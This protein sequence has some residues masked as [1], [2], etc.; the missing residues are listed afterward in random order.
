MN[1]TCTTMQTA[2]VT[3]VLSLGPLSHVACPRQ[4]PQVW[5]GVGGLIGHVVWQ[6]RTQKMAFSSYL[7]NKWN[8][9][10]CQALIY[11]EQL[12]KYFHVHR[13]S[14]LHGALLNCK[15]DSFLSHPASSEAALLSHSGSGDELQIKWIFHLNHTSFF[16]QT[17]SSQL[18]LENP[19]ARSKAS[20]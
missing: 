15:Q 3:L 5:G 7:L 18:T 10:L 11:I 1:K 4:T 8:C 19:R 17:I 9:P 20:W 12:W 16:F 14:L 2:V 6:H 13:G